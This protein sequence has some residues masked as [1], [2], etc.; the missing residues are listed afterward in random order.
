MGCLVSVV[1]GR[2]G[3]QAITAANGNRPGVG[4]RVPEL[5]LALG[6]GAGAAPLTLALPSGR[7]LLLALTA[8]LTAPTSGHAAVSLLHLAHAAPH[9]ATALTP[10]L[11][12]SAGK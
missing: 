2:R 11:G 1:R 9:P 8:A 7:A 4:A 3:S 10:G 6:P 12:N 5:R